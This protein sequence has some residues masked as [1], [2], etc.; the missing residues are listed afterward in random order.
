MRNISKWV[1]CF[2]LGFCGL[3]LIRSL[4]AE[5]P[6]LD[7]DSPAFGVEVIALSDAKDVF[8]EQKIVL[9]P[10]KLGV[11]LIH[12]EPHG[13]VAKAQ[14][15]QF[16]VITN[17]DRKP[18]QTIEEFSES[19]KGLS[20]GKTYEVAGYRAYNVRGKANWKKGTVKITPVAKRDVFLHAMR[21]KRDDVQDITIYTHLDTAEFV[22]VKSEMFCY[23]ASKNDKLSLH[24]QIQYVSEDWLFIERFIVKADDQN[25]TL[26]ANQVDR[27]N[28]VKSDGEIGIWE[29]HDRVVG[30]NERKVLD[31]IIKADKVT[32]RCE[33]RQYKKDRELSD[34]EIHRLKTVLTAYK[35][36]GGT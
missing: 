27:D 12:V 1:S 24:L 26:T 13:P 7:L 11:L 20:I 36:L 15:H 34:E 2:L 18:I 32:L 30:P 5:E 25:F 6:L 21:Q 19:V 14:L 22:N 28:G 3:F 4:S 29:W 23:F 9:P 31:A 35:I 8:K 16:D 10:T 17:I 33:G